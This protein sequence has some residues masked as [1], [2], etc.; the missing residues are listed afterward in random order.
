[1]KY[2]SYLMLVVLMIACTS[3]T[4]K[5]APELKIVGEAAELAES[6]K[7]ENPRMQFKLIKS[8]VTDKTQIWQSIDDDLLGFTRYCEYAEKCSRWCVELY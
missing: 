3:K 6:A 4:M 2:L 8:K 7:H 1:M 5:P